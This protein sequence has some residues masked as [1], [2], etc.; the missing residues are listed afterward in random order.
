MW[1]KDIRQRSGLAVVD[2]NKSLK[3]LVARQL[4]K[5]HKVQGDVRLPPPAFAAVSVRLFV[6]VCRAVVWS[7]ANEEPA[8]VCAVQCGAG[9]RPWRWPVVCER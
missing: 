3:T 1:I 8:R 4:I 9:Q 7:A 5:C 6:D 2:I